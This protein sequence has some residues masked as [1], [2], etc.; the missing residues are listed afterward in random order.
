M[1]KSAVLIENDL[2][3]IAARLRAIDDGYF[4]VYDRE[5]SSFEVHHRFQ[6]GDTFA[7]KVPYPTLDV[8]TVNL[9][10]R[11]R[12]ENREKL[13]AEMENHNRRLEERES[14]K[15]IGRLAAG[16]D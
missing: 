15:I 5:S 13:L 4:V 1:K 8:R 6:C 3:G 9:V 11:T 2:F 10:Q 7:L 12:I 14:E 16:A